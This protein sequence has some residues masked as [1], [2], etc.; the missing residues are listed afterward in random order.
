[1][2]S[3]DHQNLRCYRR[4]R[5]QTKS[6]KSRQVSEELLVVNGGK[7]TCHVHGREELGAIFYW[8]S[9]C[10]SG[11]TKLDLRPRGLKEFARHFLRTFVISRH[12][13]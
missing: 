11:A 1:M 4:S 2:T 9:V 5:R 10:V 13:P 12:D 6:V 7:Q 3:D 8:L